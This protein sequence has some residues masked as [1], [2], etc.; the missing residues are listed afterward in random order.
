MN[1]TEK[2]IGEIRVLG[3]LCGVLIREVVTLKMRLGPVLGE[4]PE[5]T[6]ESAI[7][8]VDDAGK[9][10]PPIA[11]G[12]AEFRQLLQEHLHAIRARR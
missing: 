10:A 5:E 12:S 3:N 1:D 7:A 8:L 2:L 11:E 4:S 6:L 9:A